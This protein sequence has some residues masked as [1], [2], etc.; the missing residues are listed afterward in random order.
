ML[1]HPW[2][3]CAQQCLPSLNP[4][5]YL[6]K[7]ALGE[8]ATWGASK[9]ALPGGLTHPS[10]LPWVS[11]TWGSQPALGVTPSSCGPPAPSQQWNRGNTGRNHNKRSIIS[12]IYNKSISVYS[13]LAS[14]YQNTH[15]HSQPLIWLKLSYLSCPLLLVTS[16]HYKCPT[17]LG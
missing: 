14:H 10:L 15:S 2:C 16:Q 9:P 6:Q 5:F 7:K 17:A 1:P 4:V 3:W 8:A 11:P 12:K 13:L